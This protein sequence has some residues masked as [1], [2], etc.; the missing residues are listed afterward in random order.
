M[1]RTRLERLAEDF[2]R[3][4]PDDYEQLAALCWDL[5]INEL[6][7]RFMVVRECFHISRE[8]W[9]EGEGGA[10]SGDFA[11]ALRH[12][13]ESYLLGILQAGSREEGTRLALALHEELIAL[14]SED[15]LSF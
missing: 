1:D 13:R 8:F 2:S 9:G 14:G 15:P 4:A 6:D 11:Y 3:A 5:A 10:V 7:V 12:T